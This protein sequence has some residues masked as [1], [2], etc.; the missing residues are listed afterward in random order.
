MDSPTPSRPRRRMRTVVISAAVLS[1][2]VV[3][4]G[5]LVWGG[6]RSAVYLPSGGEPPPAGDVVPGA[7]DVVLH[8]DDGLELGGWYVPSTG[9]DRDAAVLVT[10][11]NAGNRESRAPLAQ[12]LAQEGFSVLVFDYRG[13]GGNEGEPTEPGLTADARAGLDVLR[14]HGHDSDRILYWG[15]SLGAGVATNLAVEEPP[16]GLFLRSP[17]SSLADMAGSHYP[18]VPEAMLRDSYLV[19]ETVADLDLPVSVAIGETDTV[20]PAEQSHAVAEA[21]PDLVE[22]VV[23]PGT[24]HNDPAMVHGPEVVDGFVRLADEVL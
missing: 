9:E 18:M 22:E 7:E 19:Q 20:V 8:T 24:G 15:E 10:N 11:G 17:F 6:Q 23:L 3:L 2:A 1:G 13:F 16:A 5:G 4:L 21:V 12:A 14:E